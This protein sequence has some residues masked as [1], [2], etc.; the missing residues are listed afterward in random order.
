MCGRTSGRGLIAADPDVRHFTGLGWE[1]VGVLENNLAP[2]PMIPGTLPG[3]PTHSL[4]HATQEA[5]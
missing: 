3:P 5:L 4:P 1:S 2:T